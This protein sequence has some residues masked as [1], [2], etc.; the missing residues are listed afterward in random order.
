MR[1]RIL[2][3]FL[4]GILSTVSMGVVGT[5]LLS[6]QTGTSSPQITDNSATPSSKIRTAQ[7]EPDVIYVPTPQGVVDEM[8]KIAN[9]SKD[10]ILYDLGSG[11]GRIPITAAQKYG[12]RGVGVDIDPDRVAEAKNNAIKAGVTDRVQFIQQDLFETDLSKA[13]VVTLYLLQSLNIKLRPKLFKE[14]KP[15]TRIVSHA[16]NMGNWKPE[17]V[18]RKDGRTIYYWT[19]PEQIPANLK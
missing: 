7:R 15:G 10:D 12:T 18:V 1:S 9:V 13:T 2:G 4:V 3:W 14:L 11:D 19:I 16:F 8:L 5:H 17:K 6:A